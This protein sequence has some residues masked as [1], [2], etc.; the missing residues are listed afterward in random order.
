MSPSW[1]RRGGGNRDAR[2]GR[3]DSDD[4][5]SGSDAA[6]GSGAD[7]VA[8]PGRPQ[9]TA[10]GKAL[11]LLARREHSRREL[12][13]KLDQKGFEADEAGA[14]LEQLQRQSYQSDERFAQLLVRSRV[15]QG[16]GP[17]RML[18]ELRTHGIVDDAARAALDAEGADWAALAQRVYRRR[19]GVRPAQDLQEAR[20][21]AAFLL[22][23]GFDAA[24]VRVITHADD[25][26]D[27]AEAFD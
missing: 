6:S 20:R 10:Y 27:S 23:R 15:S 9:A 8:E 18:A 19:Y 13:R 4:G 21:R 7:P 12:A 14:A 24:T 1:P 5:R 17:R 2:Q 3:R 16:Q 25:V 26:D 22:R 11:G